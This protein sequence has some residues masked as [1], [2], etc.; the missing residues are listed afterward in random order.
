MAF[1]EEEIKLWNGEPP[2]SQEEDRQRKEH[3]TEQSADGIERITDVSSPTLTFYPCTG[4]GPLEQRRHPAVLV[5]PGGAYTLLAWNLEGRDI[6]FMLNQNGFSAF[7]LKYRCPDRRNGA[8]AD[9]A[10]AMRLIRSKAAYFGIDAG[11]VGTIGFSAGAHL[12]ATITAPAKNVPYPPGDEV[13]RQVFRPDFSAWIYPAYLTDDKLNLAPEFEVD[14]ACPPCLLI[15]TEDDPVNVKN[16]IAWFLAMKRVGRPVE[17]HIWPSGGH[18]Y[19]LHL[20][21]N[22]GKYLI[23][24]WF[25]R[26]IE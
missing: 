16:S 24:E 3:L 14:A 19:G 25:R 21:C 11:K 9:A 17:M 23:E 1:Y 2:F 22:H 5:C 7:L 12:C 15:Q 4:G 26:Q 13:D 20:P 10:R 18:G 8:H 6:C